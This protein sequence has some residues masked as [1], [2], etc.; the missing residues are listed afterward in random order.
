MLG[1]KYLPLNGRKYVINGVKYTIVARQ[2][3]AK[4]PYARVYCDISA[5]YKD[6][7]GK[8]WFIDLLMSES[9]LT[10]KLINK[11]EKSLTK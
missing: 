7:Q 9:Q 4:Y 2:L 6:A 5:E 3:T 8:Q 10:E 11:M 1:Q